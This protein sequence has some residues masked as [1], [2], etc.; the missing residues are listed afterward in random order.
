MSRVAGR[1]HYQS[2]HSHKLGNIGMGMAIRFEYG[3]ASYFQGNPSWEY[4]ADR[5]ADNACDCLSMHAAGG[6]R[7]SLDSGYSQRDSMRLEESSPP[8]TGPFCGRARVH[9]DFIP[10]PYD[11]ESLK[12]Q[13]S[14]LV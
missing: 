2:R 14:K 1:S 5:Q 7:Q 3:S 10:S 11:I 4:K 9:T 6:D 13:V 12:L 8:Y